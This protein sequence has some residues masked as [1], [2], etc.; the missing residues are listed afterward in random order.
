MENKQRA[1]IPAGIAE[2]CNVVEIWFLDKYLLEDDT[3]S[4]SRWV[5]ERTINLEMLACAVSNICFL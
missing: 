5:I 2:H 3:P 4:P 1:S